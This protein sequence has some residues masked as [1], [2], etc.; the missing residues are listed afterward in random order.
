VLDFHEAELAP[1][2]HKKKYELVQ[3]DATRTLPEYLQ[4]HPETIVA[5]AYFD[6][7]IYAPTK[8]CLEAVVPHLTKGSVLAFDE[9]NCP[10]FPGETHGPCAKCWACRPLRHPAR[11]LE[12]AD[13]LPRDRVMRH[14]RLPARQEVVTDGEYALVTVQ[15]AHI[16]SIRLLAQRADRRAAP[17][18]ADPAPD[19]QVAVLRA[20]DLA[21]R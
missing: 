17:G 7:D 15:D 5:L 10:E 20:A 21:Q 1:I 2:P 8:A 6:F 16:E 9:L 18:R 19:Q 11:P 14:Y 12:P 4:R 3:G 13:L